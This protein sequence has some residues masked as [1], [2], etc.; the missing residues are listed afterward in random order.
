MATDTL[1]PDHGLP[2]TTQPEHTLRATGAI[3]LAL[4]INLSSFVDR[5]T[6]DDFR[7]L[8]GSEAFAEALR[9]LHPHPPF[10]RDEATDAVERDGYALRIFRSR[11]VYN[12]FFPTYRFGWDSTMRA[13]LA[14]MGCADVGRWQHWSC[15]VRL[16]RNGLA[17]ITLDQ[18][19]EGIRLIECTEQILELPARSAQ[20][21]AQDQ[22]SIGMTILRA[23]LD[24]I[25]Q[26]VVLNVHG[27]EREIRFTTTAQFKHSLRLDRYV[28]YTFR[29]IERDGRLLMPDDLKRDYAQTLASFMEGALVECDGVRR[30][31]IYAPVQARAL[32]E[33]D[34]SSW[35]E[36][37]CLFTGESALIY[38]PLVGRGLA[39]VGGPLG[40]DAHA[41]STYWAGIVRGIEH[42]VAFRSEAQQAERRT[43]DLLS[44]I[45]GLTRKVNDGALTGDDLALIDH[46][47]AGL[48]DIFDGLPELRS[49]AVS[50]NA[51]RADYARRKFEV[52][53]RELDVQETLDLVNTNV[54][55][56]D[57]F[58]SYYNGMRLQWQGQHTNSLGILLAAVVL[59]MAVSSF[60]ADTFNVA[61]RLVPQSDRDRAIQTFGTEIVIAAVGLLILGLMLW[62][63]RKLVNRRT[64]K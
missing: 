64:R 46:L 17:V 54:E 62:Q 45:P 57:F 19:F 25:D 34:V 40:L 38:H 32:V 18:P 52:L 58:L 2:E 23:F 6:A 28:I 60:L 29:R 11:L 30:Y 20:P 49:M 21:A 39:Y 56:L 12:H 31:P 51:F 36:E 42:L 59:F 44:R 55:Q 15:R 13:R 22:W 53:M 43:T 26:R 5:E 8:R 24:A 37:L 35:D 3:R 9:N 1:V 50:T 61:D 10:G 48:S 7:H 27:Q 63:A 14:E 4:V 16:T 47:A 33:S 41:Y